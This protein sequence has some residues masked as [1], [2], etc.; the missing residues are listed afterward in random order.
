MQMPYRMLWQVT[1]KYGQTFRKKTQWSIM[2]QC[3]LL[4]SELV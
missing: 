3:Y 2:L 4:H 1:E